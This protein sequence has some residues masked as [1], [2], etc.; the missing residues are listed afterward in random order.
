M[1][2]LGGYAYIPGTNTQIG[3]SND[4]WYSTDAITWTL[5]TQR[6]S[7]SPPR[8]WTS[9][10]IDDHGEFMWIMGG[11]VPPPVGSQQPARLLNDVWRGTSKGR[12]W[13]RVDTDASGEEID[14]AGHWA[15]RAEHSVLLHHNTALKV[16]VLYVMGGWVTYDLRAPQ[17]VATI[18]DVWVSSDGG[19]SWKELT[20]YG[21]E[22][23]TSNMWPKRWGHSSFVTEKGVLLVAGGTDTKTGNQAQY[24]TYKDLWA[25]FDGGYNWYPCKLPTNADFIRAEQ[26]MQV[27]ADQRLLLISGYSFNNGSQGTGRNDYSDVYISN[28]S[29]AD[30]ATLI[31][32]CG[33]E[34]AA[35]PRGTMGL[36]KW[37]GQGDGTTA[38]KTGPLSGAAIAGIVFSILIVVAVLGYC[39]SGYQRTGR[40]PIP[41]VGGPTGSYDPSAAASTDYSAFSF[42]TKDE[43][44]Q[45]ADTNGSNGVNGGLHSEQDSSSQYLS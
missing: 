38:K 11:L 5:Q 35:P 13:Q 1:Y 36:S 17:R 23:V 9:C 40:W 10:D 39:V 16:D 27:T 30:T 19:V 34:A 41:F 29:L 18:N 2:S 45:P 21:T 24:V 28:V 44:A 12:Q 3:G 6:S 20:G 14:P 15:P 43:G 32:I 33:G 8:A 25:S 7:F 31:N 4:V 37:P 22:S 42:G 26:S